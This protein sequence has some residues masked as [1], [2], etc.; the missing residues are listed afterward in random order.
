[1]LRSRTTVLLTSTSRVPTNAC[2]PTYPVK[3][4]SSKPVHRIQRLLLLGAV[5]LGCFVTLFVMYLNSSTG[6]QSGTVESIAPSEHPK[7]IFTKSDRNVTTVLIWLWPFGEKRSKLNACAQEFGVDGCFITANR[8]FYQKSDGV[9]IHHHDI[10]SDLSNLPPLQRPSFQKWIWMNLESPS[11][12][13]KLGGINDL[14]NLTL[15]YRLDADIPV[16]YGSLVSSQGV[17]DFIPPK[18]NK[19]LCWIVSN[20]NTSYTRVKY[21]NELEKHIKVD[22]Y[23]RA[24][25][26]FLT[27]QKYAST[28][29]NCKFYLAFENSIHKDYITEKFFNPLGAGTV[30]VVLGPPRADYENV[31]QGDAFIHV[32]DFAS[33]KDLA[34]YLLLLDK[35]EEIYLRY[36]EWRKHFKVK[37]R[38]FL[39]EHACVACDYLRRHRESQVVKNLDKWFWG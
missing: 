22:V 18:K 23:G 6:W 19:L 29:T 37:R 32:D 8:N 14:F 11:R 9:V 27:T 36:F 7:G 31:I 26:K 15:N 21:Y 2:L 10:R 39:T 3:V 28:L 16:P 33:P 30:P 4:M 1:M 35:N 20:W 25:N 13:S 5:I 38:P 12:S 24:F 34:D 17:D